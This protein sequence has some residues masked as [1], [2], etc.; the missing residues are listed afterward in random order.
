MAGELLRELLIAN[1]AAIVAIAL[2]L[3]LRPLVRKVFGLQTAHRLWLIPLATSAAGLLPA[4]KA[5]DPVATITARAIPEETL[6]NIQNWVGPPAATAHGLPISVSGL[7]AVVWLAGVVCTAGFILVRQQRTVARLG[8][9]V[10]A[11][12]EAFWR[13]EKPA[14]GPALIGVTRPKLVVPADFEDRYD[15]AE[16]RLVLSHEDAHLAAGHTWINGIAALIQCLNWFNPLV[17]LAVHQARQDQ[18][19][20][21]DAAVVARF[22]G[23]RRT[24]AEALLKTQLAPGYLPLGC[25]WPTRSPNLLRERIV[26]LAKE[27]PSLRR[28]LIGA[29]A[30]VTVGL[31]IGFAAWAADQQPSLAA[32]RTVDTEILPRL[33]Q[34]ELDRNWDVN[35]TIKN[36]GPRR[37]SD[38]FQYSIYLGRELRSHV[39]DG[40]GLAL[41][42]SE[43]A[44]LARPQKPCTR[45]FDGKGFTLETPFDGPDEPDEYSFTIYGAEPNG[46]V[47]INQVWVIDG[48]PEIIR[49][50]KV[51]SHQTVRIRLRD[52]R[53]ITVTPVLRP[54]QPGDDQIVD[55]ST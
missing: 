14:M 15:E 53:I 7:L 43:Q 44:P 39:P 13:A 51:Q 34:A 3:L 4:A 40:F 6:V 42:E 10:R 19:L 11:P 23:E 55:C 12:G 18:E 47:T 50:L 45:W 9:L 20:A 36:F 26:M 22:P 38:A 24:Y 25:T 54:R 29:V 2:V 5:G 8:C 17:H 46:L 33:P 41:T 28:R 37:E 16:Q 35:K 1:L 52:R 31:G 27:T 49:N 30:I 32:V 48:Q 21:C